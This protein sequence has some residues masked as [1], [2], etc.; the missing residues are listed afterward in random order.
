MIIDQ[1]TVNEFGELRKYIQF[2]IDEIEPLGGFYYD[3]MRD[4]LELVLESINDK[5]GPPTGTLPPASAS[6]AGP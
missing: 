3:G 4:G 2:L 6:S 1:L 5:V